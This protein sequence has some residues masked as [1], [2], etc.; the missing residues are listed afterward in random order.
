MFAKQTNAL[1]KAE[2]NV[3]LR[4]GRGCL[5]SPLVGRG[6]GAFVNAPYGGMRLSFVGWGS[7]SPPPLRGAPSRREPR[8]GCI[9]S[10]GE[11]LPLPFVGRG[12]LMGYPSPPALQEPL[13]G[14][15]P[16]CPFAV[17]GSV[18][19]KVFLLWGIPP[20]F[21]APKFKKWAKNKQK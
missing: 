11:G 6:C 14:E 13:P 4:A 20:P 8:R 10:V 15:K 21:A 1:G 19:K 12:R 18:C 9:F 17:C 5:R 16:F 3:H 7:R 2:G